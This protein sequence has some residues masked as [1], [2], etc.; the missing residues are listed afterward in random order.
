VEEQRKEQELT[1]PLTLPPLDEE[2]LS[3]LRQRYE[4]SPDAETRTRYQMLLLSL[5]GQKSSQIAHT[6]LRSQD[7]VQRV[8]KRFLAEGLDTVPRRTAPG[9]ARTITD[10][11]EAEL[12]RVIEL[13]PH[14]VGQDTTNWTTEGLA[15]Y[16]GQQTGIEVTE[17]TVRLYLHAHDYVCKRPTWTLRRKAEQKADYV[18]NACG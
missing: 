8:L 5:Q 2:A 18:G 12:L 3:E 17:E 14:E 10:A 6:V 15:Q 13:D 4:Q 7:T 9:R 1:K 16:L 11:W